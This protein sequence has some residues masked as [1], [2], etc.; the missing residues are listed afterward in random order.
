M[1]AS[2]CRLRSA[3]SKIVGL[4][5]SCS[6]GLFRRPTDKQVCW[7]F[8]RRK[9]WMSDDDFLDPEKAFAGFGLNRPP[10]ARAWR[11]IA[12]ALLREAVAL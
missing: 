11:K 1:T 8:T 9:I 12:S 2:Q 4:P 5:A 3:V 10:K 7:I 6:A